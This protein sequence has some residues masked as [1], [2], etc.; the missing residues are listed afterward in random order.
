MLMVLKMSG[1][2]S[3]TQSQQT[4]C[5]FKYM[6]VTMQGTL[7]G[8]TPDNVIFMQLLFKLPIVICVI[9]NTQCRVKF[10]FSCTCT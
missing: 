2:V 6:H 4:V 3:Q 7:A 1:V 9:M 8:S 10:H 5:T